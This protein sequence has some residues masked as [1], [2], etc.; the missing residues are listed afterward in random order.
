VIGAA[1]SVFLICLFLKSCQ[2]FIRAC[3][4]PHLPLIPI[5]PPLPCSFLVL[6]LGGEKD[7]TRRLSSA[8]YIVSTKEQ[9]NERLRTVS[10]MW[11][12]VSW[13]KQLTAEARVHSQ[14]TQALVGKPLGK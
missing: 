5:P 12:G 8:R 14:G 11:V 3:C 6:F 10:V 2:H 7:T 13:N 4:S 1:E 9:T